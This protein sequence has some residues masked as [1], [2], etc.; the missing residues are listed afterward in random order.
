[1]QSN[2]LAMNKNE[3]DFSKY[4]MCMYEIFNPFPDHTM[5]VNVYRQ[6]NHADVGM[7]FESTAN[8]KVTRRYLLPQGSKETLHQYVA[9]EWREEIEEPFETEEVKGPWRTLKL[10]YPDRADPFFDLSHHMENI[11]T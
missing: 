10:Q 6:T 3:G 2:D 1:M 8:A 11:G 4:S 9:G 5:Y 7:Y